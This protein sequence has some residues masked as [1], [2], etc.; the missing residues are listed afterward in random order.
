VEKIAQKKCAF[1]NESRLNNERLEKRQVSDL[2]KKG[3]SIRAGSEGNQGPSILGPWFNI[4]KKK[5][6]TDAGGRGVAD[7]AVLSLKLPEL[8]SN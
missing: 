2:A 4:E 7:G 5:T 6:L 1:A 8:M 3:L